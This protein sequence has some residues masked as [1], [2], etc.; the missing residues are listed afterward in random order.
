MLS[1]KTIALLVAMLLAAALGNGPA[2]LPHSSGLCGDVGPVTIAMQSRS[3]LGAGAP[4]VP[5]DPKRSQAPLLEGATM[6][7]RLASVGHVNLDEVWKKIMWGGKNAQYPEYRGG[8]FVTHATRAAR[9]LGWSV[10]VV[11]LVGPDRSGDFLRAELASTG[12]DLRGLRLVSSPTRIAQVIEG[13]RPTI[14]KDL[15]TYSA[16]LS[17]GA[18]EKELLSE[19]DWILAGGSLD[20]DGSDRVLGEL[21]TVARELG[22]PLFLNPSRWHD[23]DRLDLGDIR[24]IQLSRDDFTALGFAPE[25]PNREV[26]KALLGKG[27]WCVVITDAGNGSDGFTRSEELNMPAEAVPV[28]QMRY[29]AGAGD[30]VAAAH[31]IALGLGGDLWRILRFG[32]VSGAMYVQHGRGITWAEAGKLMWASSKG[33]KPLPSDCNGVQGNTVTDFANNKI[34]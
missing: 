28:D 12:A 2:V 13:A 1:L 10:N 23:L 30:T 14:L 4:A 7:K 20:H 8:G 31:T 17:F 15:R 19:G 11:S 16:A 6:R 34:G 29:A 24:L 3:A 21:I 27:V 9:T 25:T 18:T 32:V 22:K 33:E 26:A 5:N